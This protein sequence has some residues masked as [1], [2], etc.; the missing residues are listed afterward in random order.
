MRSDHLERILGKVEDLDSVNLTSLVQRLARE[1]RVLETVF[2][3]I[4]EG[5]L[6]ID[7]A[8]VVEYSNEAASAMVALDEKDLGKVVLWKLVPDL[9]KSV[10]VEHLGSGELSIISRELEI[11]YPENRYIRLYLMPFGEEDTSGKRF[12]V[13]LADITEEKLSTEEM[14]ENE[15]IS[16]L[17][18]LA[19]GVAHEL[20][21]PLNSIN[22]HLQLMQRQLAKLKKGKDVQQMS[23]S[24]GV[25][26]G[27]IKRLE[28]I[29]EHFL[30]AISPRVPEM[31]E[32]NL[33]ML[34]DENLAFQAKELESLGVRVEVVLKAESTEILGDRN[35]IK[36]VFF[37]VVKNAIEAMEKAG[38]LKITVESD[39]E[40]VYFKFKDTGAGIENE[41][42][43]KVFEP[44]YSTK[45]EGYG[46]GMMIVQRIMRDHGGK[47][48]IDSHKGIGTCVTLQFPLKAKRIRMLETEG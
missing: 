22:I 46:L 34:L 24:V 32:L 40:S 3:T 8:G 29:I 1:R 4:R 11:T 12:I 13:I 43:A 14:I 37:N 2:N 25:C 15:K 38:H 30:N 39:D 18:K 28:G 47:I 6:I 20:G 19:A 42:L 16:S 7:E 48:G 21:N 17:F 5:I 41:A 31:N 26:M 44:Y 35:Q 36:Q 27:E 33:L 10:D 45:E 23:D 9:V